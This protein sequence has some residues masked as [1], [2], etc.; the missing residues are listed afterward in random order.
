MLT[1]FFRLPIFFLS[2]CLLF[3]LSVP[4]S[5]THAEVGYSTAPPAKKITKKKQLKKR[6]RAKRRQAQKK[7]DNIVLGLYLTFGVLLLLPILVITGTLL[8][9]FGFPGLPAYILGIGLIGLG[10]L[11]VI[12]AGAF[13]GATNTYDTQVLFF[14]VWFLFGL[15]IGALLTFL[16][17]Y[18]LV[19]TGAPLLLFAVIFTTITSLV[20]LIWGLVIGQGKRQFQQ[21]N[22][23]E[24]E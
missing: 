10:N 4:F 6:P 24:E 23:L 22:H 13:T 11:G 8:L 20:F 19:F 21:V 17:L 15:N 16:L 18:L 7:P 1:N 9:T 5:V 12:L 14:G 3:C 2:L